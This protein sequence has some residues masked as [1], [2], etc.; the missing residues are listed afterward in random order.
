MGSMLLGESWREVIKVCQK[1]IFTLCL[2]LRR[3][4]KSRPSYH[5]PQVE[6][7]FGLQTDEAKKKKKFT[8]EREKAIFE[9]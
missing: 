1:H 2:E 6:Y 5:H 7:Q 8:L 4:G 3:C 9:E